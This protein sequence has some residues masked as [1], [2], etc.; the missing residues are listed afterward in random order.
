MGPAPSYRVSLVYR[1]KQAYEAQQ[2]LGALR[3]GVFSD[4]SGNSD[5]DSAGQPIVVGGTAPR[6]PPHQTHNPTMAQ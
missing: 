4:L 1:L 5:G 3:S 6:Q 2:V